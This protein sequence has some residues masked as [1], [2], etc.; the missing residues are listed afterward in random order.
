MCS[1]LF[2]KKFL[3]FLSIRSL[4][5][6]FSF[7]HSKSF[8]ISL[9]ILSLI[10]SLLFSSLKF[11]LVMLIVVLVVFISVFPIQ[12]F[13][14]HL[15]LCFIFQNLDFS[16]LYVV[17]RNWNKFMILLKIGFR[18]L[19]VLGNTK[20]LWIMQ[21]ITKLASSSFISSNNFLWFFYKYE[22]F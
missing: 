9:S 8:L 13:F 18:I 15:Y 14:L 2:S 3:I 12:K 7:S 17:K 19:V 20:M 16:S 10:S 6:L 4:I 5:V 1:S 11:F 22:N 21:I